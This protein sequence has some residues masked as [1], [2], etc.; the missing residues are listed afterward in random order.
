MRRVI[1]LI[2]AAGLTTSAC[3]GIV[4]RYSFNSDAN[5][6]TGTRHGVLKG[7][8]AAAEGKLKLDGA[9][10]VELPGGLVASWTSATME[11]WFT[12]QNHG[13]YVRVFDFGDTNAKG[14][15]AHV[16]YFSPMC[17]KAARTVFS[18]TDPGYTREETI[19]AKVLPENTVFHVVVV[20]DGA[21]KKARL[22]IDDRLIGERTMTVKLSEVGTQH[23]YLGKSSYNSDP[24]LK[25]TIDE[26][27][28]YNDAMT[29]L[30]RRLNHLL[31]P[32]KVQDCVLTSVSPAPDANEVPIPAVLKWTVDKAVTVDHYEVASGTDRQALGLA[33]TKTPSV[34]STKET[35]L[36]LSQLKAGATCYWRV[37]TVDSQGR[38]Y[39]GPVVS[40]TCAGGK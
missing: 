11:V 29:D 38:R 19:D 31:G 3:A 8:A 25:G 37:D 6:A 13:G 1:S 39:L 20:Y 33:A 4:D 30:Q 14:Q 24:L 18:N 10:W 26:F 5:D 12:Y 27:R 35:Q 40:F 9:G 36:T 16:W 7:T 15:G 23:L 34:V 22:Y 32:D 21:A 28:V 17:P 2:L